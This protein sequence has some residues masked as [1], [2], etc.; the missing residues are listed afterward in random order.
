MFDKTIILHKSETC[1]I[2]K[3]E[4]TPPGKDKA[5]LVAV[6]KIDKKSFN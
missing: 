2:R 6:K 3:G 1:E 5:I 4:Y